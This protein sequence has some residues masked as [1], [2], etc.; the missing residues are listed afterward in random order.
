GIN[1]TYF[2]DQSNGQW[3]NPSLFQNMYSDFNAML[4]S[5]YNG[6]NTYVPTTTHQRELETATGGLWSE[7]MYHVRG[8]EAPICFELYRNL[9]VMHPDFEPIVE[10]NSTHL[11][12]EWKGIYG[13]FNPVASH[14]QALWLDVRPAFDYL[15]EMT[16]RLTVDMALVSIIDGTTDILNVEVNATCYGDRIGSVEAILVMDADD[17]LVHYWDGVAA[18][19]EINE[20]ATLDLPVDV[21][22]RNYSIF[23]GNDYI[24]YTEFILSQSGGSGSEP[25]DLV[26]LST[27]A[28]ATIGIIIVVVI[29]MKKRSV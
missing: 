1:A 2:P 9:T 4:P 28:I 11:T 14:I 24:G 10:E 22:F 25:L 20:V 23:V 18:N 21:S 13:Y 19:G 15:L 8:S 12:R 26:L 7:W 27:L 17:E 6:P 29:V 5:S 3:A 16:P